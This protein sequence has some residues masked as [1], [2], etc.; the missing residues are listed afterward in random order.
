[1]SPLKFILILVIACCSLCVHAASSDTLV[2]IFD[3][4][5][6]LQGD[7]IE[8]E[9][10]TEPFSQDQPAQTLHLWIENIQ[11]GQRW[12]YRYPYT[13]GRYKFSLRIHDSIPVG[14]YA[15]NFLLQK[16]F[17]VL[18][19]KLK[20]AG[21]DDKTL[22]YIAIANNKAPIIDGIELRNDGSFTIDNIF[23]T[24]SVYFAFSPAE[25]N[26]A[27]RLKISI[28]T[29]LDSVF[30]PE[31]VLTEYVT[32]G[33]NE[34]R[35]APMQN[36]MNGYA[37]SAAGKKDKQLLEELVVKTKRLSKRQL[38]EKENVSGLFDS[39]NARTFDFYE[40]DELRNYPDIY[41]Y[42]TAYVPGLTSFN[43]EL[44]GR[45]VLYWR[46]EKVN[47]YVDE[48][49]DVDFSPLSVNVQDIELVKVY[50]PGSRLGLDG[51]NG[52]VA[53]YTRRLSNRPGNKISNY[54]FYV[55][56]FT[57]KNAEWK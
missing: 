54:S 4:Q 35:D 49:L 51:F 40:N 21:G 50:S 24:D 25:K 47:I 56:G 17:L 5:N 48:V 39:Q 3:R 14:N 15:F 9:V 45:T 26:K 42:L 6:L 44:T 36:P 11:T 41:S 28:E 37:F 16:K 10:Y 34:T 38:F 46:N 7:S 33:M 52:S 53:I 30:I 57:Q 19:G 29:P 8:M 31:T 23:Y 13:R 12:K 32:V 18:N 22:N 20:N 1:M 43:D 55:K 2:V 27:N